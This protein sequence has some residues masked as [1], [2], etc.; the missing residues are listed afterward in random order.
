[1][2]TFLSILAEVA[3]NDNSVIQRQLWLLRNHPE[4][5]RAQVYDQARKEFY[6]LRLQE[7]VRRQVAK[8]EAMA[9]GAYFGKSLL[10]I[11]MEFEE[12]EYERWRFWAEQKAALLE[13]SKAAGSMAI[14]DDDTSVSAE[15]KQELEQEPRG[16]V[17]GAENP[18]NAAL[19]V[20]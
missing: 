3:K 6:E 16:E 17:E 19:N 7:E 12:K 18:N 14:T 20:I 15:S 2:P 4:L 5:T 1:M 11:G 10:E 13:Q 8:E 9:T